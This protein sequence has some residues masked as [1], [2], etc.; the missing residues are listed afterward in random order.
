MLFRVCMNVRDYSVSTGSSAMRL[1]QH[2][3]MG[4][5]LRHTCLLKD[6]SSS[7]AG[8]PEPTLATQL[9][10]EVQKYRAQVF[11]ES[12]KATYKTH[13]DTYLRFCLYM[14]YPPIPVQTVHLLQY[15]AFLARSL[16]PASVRSYLNIIGILHKEFGLPNPLLD[17]WPLKSLLTGIKRALGT[18]PNQKLPITPDILVRLHDS[19][20]FTS[21]SDSSFWAICLVA[22]Y[23]MFRKSHLLP[24]S[25][26]LF[27]PSKQ[28]TKGDFKIFSWGMLVTI[29]W[30]KT[31][32]F[33]ERVVEIP[34]PFIPRSK[35]CPTLAVM[36]AFSFTDHFPSS[37]QAFAW[38]DKRSRTPRVFTYN[39]FLTKL[40]DSLSLIGINPKLYAGHSFRRGGA[41]FAYQ[42]GVPIELIKASGDW[43][44][45]TILIYLTMPLTIRLRSANMLCKSILTHTT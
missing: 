25:S 3:L 4:F 7:L 5:H 36:H 17:N 45:D 13:R 14:G 10:H 18:T 27:D 23:G 1:P 34:L 12:T 43:R 41:S 38:F 32:Q 28:L 39:E 21:S 30:S 26:A 20:D 29:R 42:S 9:N 40:H 22:F 31:I 33:R 2:W 16:K 19:L 15:A 6:N 37:C 35:L 44:S 11:A 8:P 24:L